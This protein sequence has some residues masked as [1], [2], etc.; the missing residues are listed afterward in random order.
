VGDIDAYLAE[1]GI[2]SQA[3][4]IDGEAPTGAFRLDDVADIAVMPGRA[5]G[6]KCARSWKYGDDVGADPRYPDLTARDADAVA[7]WD[8]LNA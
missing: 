5:K 7:H 6:R 4:L 3:R 2:T 1:I 8:A